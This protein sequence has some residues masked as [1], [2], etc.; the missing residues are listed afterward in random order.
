MNSDKILL[1]LV[2]LFTTYLD[3]LNSLPHSDF[4]HGEMTAFVETLEIIQQYHDDT[5]KNL[6]YVIEEKYKI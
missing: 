2:D 4:V 6:N 3:E 5:I 1:Y